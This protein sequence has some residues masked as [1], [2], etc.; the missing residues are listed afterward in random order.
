LLPRRT[1]THPHLSIPSTSFITNQTKPK[2]TQILADA[3]IAV[4]FIRNGFA[5]TVRFAFT[6]WL[7]G[8]G[9]QNT[10]ILIG[11]IAL[12]SAVVPVCLLVWGKGARVRTAERYEVFAGRRVVARGV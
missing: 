6:A 10:F 7:E 11:M 2:K 5:A 9:L 4:V 12:V 3:L 8:M 1:Y